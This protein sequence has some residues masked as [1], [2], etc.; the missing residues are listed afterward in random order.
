MAVGL[1]DSNADLVV[2]VMGVAGKHVVTR[3]HV[4]IGP[5]YAV[6]VDSEGAAAAADAPLVFKAVPVATE[7]GH[8]RKAEGDHGGP[9]D[10]DPLGSDRPG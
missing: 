9:S 2:Q 5:C 7:V 1:G 3:D 6:V 10:S 8:K 4:G